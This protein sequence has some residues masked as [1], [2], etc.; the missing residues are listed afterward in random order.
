MLCKL[1]WISVLLCV[2][3][4]ERGQNIQAVPEQTSDS[5]ATRVT[6]PVIVFDAV[7]LQATWQRFFWR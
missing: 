2:A 1:L 4:A 3:C 5:F 7:P 6:L